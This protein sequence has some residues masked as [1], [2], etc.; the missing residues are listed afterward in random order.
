MHL[1]VA[2]AAGWRQAGDRHWRRAQ[3]DAEADHRQIHR[4]DGG[5]RNPVGFRHWMVESS[6]RLLCGKITR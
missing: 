5:I 3:D 4:L 6:A 1:P 2:T